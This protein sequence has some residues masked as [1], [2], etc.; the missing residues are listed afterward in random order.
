MSSIKVGLAVEVDGRSVQF[1][2]ASKEDTAAN[3]PMVQSFELAAGA[4]REIA[5][6][7]D[8]DGTSLHFLLI[9]AV[10]NSDPTTLAEVSYCFDDGSSASAASYGSWKVVSGIGGSL[11]TK[12][13]LSTQNKLYVYNHGA[14][15]I[16]VAVIADAEGV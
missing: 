11:W 10:L 7:S 9:G 1:V 4:L 8:S 13:A 6:H 15:R 2:P 12:Q 3:A 5:F 14:A 16:N